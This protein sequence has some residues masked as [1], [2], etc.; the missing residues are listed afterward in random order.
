MRTGGVCRGMKRLTNGAYEVIVWLRPGLVGTCT[1]SL[2]PSSHTFSLHLSLSLSNTRAR[3]HPSPTLD[4]HCP[5]VSQPTGTSL[6]SALPGVRHHPPRAAP[7]TRVIENRPQIRW[8]V[9]VCLTGGHWGRR[10]ALL[11]FQS[12]TDALLPEESVSSATCSC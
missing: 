6:S 2:S 7:V 12:R 11:P 9:A 10:P 8:R 1:L 4:R 3:P 5:F